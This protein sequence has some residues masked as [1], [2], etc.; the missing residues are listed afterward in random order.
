MSTVS[1][2][3]IKP[4][5]DELGSKN[6]EILPI[7]EVG[8]LAVGGTQLA[9]GYLNNAEKTA[10]AFIDSPYGI[11]YRTGDKAR[12][13]QDGTL[14][15]MGRI[16][17]GQVKLRGQ[18]IEL[19]E[20]EHA[21]LKTRGCHGVSVRVIGAILVAFCAVESFITEDDITGTCT[22]WL[23]Q[24]MVPGEVI[25]MEELPRLPSGKVDTK[26]LQTEF[27]Q[28]KDQFKAGEDIIENVDENLLQVLQGFFGSD[29]SSKTDLVRRG[30]DSLTAIGL[31]SN[32][33]RAG[34]DIKATSLLKVKT[35]GNILSTAI[36]IE[37]AD[38]DAVDDTSISYTGKLQEIQTH[39]LESELAHRQ[40]QDVIPCTSLQIA[41]LSETLRIGSAY[42][43]TVQ[44][45]VCTTTTPS[46]ILVAIH[47]LI[48]HNEDLRS[49]FL[50]HDS[51]FYCIIFDGIHPN[52][53][54]IS[55]EP[56]PPTTTSSSLLQ[57]FKIHIQQT[58]K[59]GVYHIQLHLHHSIYD[60]WTLDLLKSDLAK[61]I[62]KERLPER[63]QF[64]DVVS[65]LQSRT[66]EQY[67]ERAKV[68]W[69]DYL[70]GWSKSPF[71]RLTPKVAKSS[72]IQTTQLL[73]KLPKGGNQTYTGSKQ[74]PFQAALSLVWA[75][76]VGLQDVV[77]G[78]VT[79]GRTIPVNNIENIMGPCI[80]S[81]PLRINMESMTTID[82]LVNSISSSNRRMM[83]HTTLSQ[84]GIK[85]L[86]NLYGGD[87]LYDVL[88]VYQE[89][90]EHQNLAGC[91]V[92]ELS[93]IDRLETRLVLEVYPGQDEV[94]LQATFHDADF[95]PD[96]VEIILRQISQISFKICENPHALLSSVTCFEQ[97]I[98][99]YNLNLENMKCPPS[100]DDL[101][102]IVEH[103]VA[104]YPDRLAVSFATEI[105]PAIFNPNAISFFELNRNA[106]RIAH[107]LLSQGVK[108]GDIIPIVMNKSIR[109]YTTILGILKAG[110]GYLPLLPTTP[111]ARIA[112]IFNQAGSSLCLADEGS[113]RA[114]PPMS[115]VRLIL[116]D[117]ESME[118]FSGTNPSVRVDPSS[119]A[120]V[121]YTSGT[122]GTPKGVTVSQKNI[123]SNVTYLG[124]TYPEAKDKPLNFL[125]ACSQAFDVS[126][127][128]IFYAWHRGM[129]LCA[130]PNDVLFADLEEA[131]RKFEIT[132]LSL[133]PTI[134]SL[135][136][137]V[138]VPT[139]DFLVTAGEPMTNAVHA[140]WNQLLWQ[141]YGPSETT[142]ICSVKKMSAD[143]YIEHLGLVFDNTSVVV[144]QPMSFSTL[145]IGWAGELCFGGDQ[146]ANGYLNMPRLTAEKFFEHPTYGRIYR[147]GDLG[148][149]LPD[150]SL[151]I[152]GRIDDQI[153]LRGQRIE[154]AEV[155][156]IVSQVTAATAA[157]TLVLKQ[158][159]SIGEWLVTFYAGSDS[160]KDLHVLDP[161]AELQGAVFAELHSRL[162]PYMVPSYL[163]PVS[164][165]P[166]TS[167]G[168]VDKRAINAMFSQLSKEYLQ[169]VVHSTTRDDDRDWNEAERSVALV[170]A[171]SLGVPRAE[172]GRWTPLAI[173]GLDSI[174]A[175]QVSRSLSTAFTITVPIS[176]VLKRP[177][178]AQL[179]KML[180]HRQANQKTVSSRQYFDQQ[181]LKSITDILAKE[182]K[183]VCEVLPCSPLQEAMASRGK[184]SYYNKSLLRLRV[185]PYEMRGYWQHMCDRHSI[186]RTCF[187]ST[188]STKYP[189][190]QFVL[191]SWE[192]PWHEFTVT[193]PSL[194]NAIGE[195]LALVPE[196]LD[197]NTPPLSLALIRYRESSF[198]SFICHH[199]LYDGVAMECLWREVEAL[200]RG[201]QL[202]PAI[203]YGPFIHPIMNLPEDNEK[204]WKQQLVNFQPALLFPHFDQKSIEQVTHT[205]TIDRSLHTA[206]H[207]IK[208]LGISL[209][210]VCQAAITRV[211]AQVSQQNDVCFGNVMNGRTISVDGIERLVAPCF[212]TVP[213]RQNL[214]TPV[215]NID[216]A[217]DLLE[218]NTELLEHQ[219]TPLRQVQ[220]I[221]ATDT[222][223]LF[224]A[225]LLVQQPLQEMDDKIWTLEEDAGTM[226]LPLVCEV[227]PCPSLD[228][229]IL[230]L[231]YDM[232]SVP[233]ELATGIAELFKYIFRQILE[234]PHAI[235]GQE[236]IPDSLRD[237]IRHHRLHFVSD[238][239]DE[240]ETENSDFSW[241][242]E[243]L[244]VRNVLSE[245]SE[246]STGNIERTTSLFKLGLDSIN[247]VQVASLLRQRHYLVSASDI[248]ECQSCLKIARRIF[249]NGYKPKKDPGQY[250]FA[251]FD[252]EARP[253][254]QETPLVLEVLPCT[255]MQ[256]AML[257]SFLSSEG[258]NYLNVVSLE[259]QEGIS[260][261]NVADKWAD[262][263]KAHSMLRTGFAPIRHTDCTYAMLQYENTSQRQ[264]MH[265]SQSF[266]HTS[267]M[268]DVSKDIQTDLRQPPWRLAIVTRSDRVTVH[269]A[270]HHAIY[271]ATSLQQMLTYFGKLL[272]GHTVQ[273]VE[274]AHIGLSQIVQRSK[275]EMEAASSFWKQMGE[276]VT[277]NKFPVLTPLREVDRHI[278]TEGISSVLAV[279]DIH[280]MT[281]ALG[282]SVQTAIL[283]SWTRVL[284][285]YTGEEAVVFGVTLSGRTCEST[286]NTPIPCLTTV[287]VVAQN[288]ASNRNLLDQLMKWV[289]NMHQHQFLPLSRIQKELGY[290]AAAVFDTLVAYQKIEQD[291]HERPWIQ[292]EDDATVE[293]P[294]SLEVEPSLDG[295]IHIRLTYFSDVLPSEQA[296]LLL[297]Q[298]DATIENLLRYPDGQQS[299]LHSL[300]SEIFAI[301]PPLE[302]IMHAPVELLHQFVEMRARLNPDR[303]A[304]EHVSGFHENEP[305]R[306][307]WTFAELDSMGNRVAN[308]L[309]SRTTAGS[310]IAVHFDKYPEA[311]FAILGIL[312][313]GSAFVAL[314]FNAPNAR[315]EFILQ[316]SSA[317]ILL[318]GGEDVIDF[319][320]PCPVIVVDEALLNEYSESPCAVN[321]EVSPSSTCYCLYTSGT[322]GTPKGCEITHENTVQCMMAFQDLFKGH[323]ADNSR[324]LQFAALHFDV[325]VLE[326]YW[327]WSVGMAVVAA[328]KDLILD[329]LIGFIN[330]VNITHI[331]LT[332]SLARL[333]HPDT[334][335]S[336]CQ[337]VFITGGEQLKQ[338]ILDAWGSKAVIYNAYGP[339]EATIGVTTYQRVPQNGR[340]SNI[341]RQFRNVGSYVFQKDTEIPVFRGAVGELCVSGKLVGKGYLNRP[342]LTMEKFPILKIFGERIYR[343]GDLV[344]ILHDGCFEFLG[345]AD[346]QVK[347][348]G[349]RLE[350]GEIDHVIRS[351]STIHDVATLVAKHTLSGKDVLVSFIVREKMNGAPLCVLKDSNGISSEAKDVCRDK[352][353]G[354]MVPSYFLLLPY[355][356]LSP[357]NKAEAKQLRKI[358]AELS[359]EDLVSF[360]SSAMKRMVDT[361]GANYQ[362]LINLISKFCNLDQDILTPSASIF[363][364]GVDSITVLQLSL[365]LVDGG[366][367]TAS[368][369]LILRNPVVADLAFALSNT[370]LRDA[371]TE[372]RQVKLAVQACEH[373]FRSLVFR[374]LSLSPLEVEYIYPCSPLQQGMLAKTA[375]EDGQGSYFNTFRLLLKPNASL[376]RFKY[377]LKSLIA[378]EP[379]LRTTFIHSPA[380]YIQVARRALELPYKEYCLA[381]NENLDKLLD[382]MRQEWIVANTPQLRV[383]LEVVGVA[384]ENNSTWII[385]HIFHG[386]YDGTSF[387]LM[388]KKLV[389]LYNGSET[390]PGSSFSVALLHG[391]LRN[392]DDAKEEWKKHL[393]GWSPANLS[394]AAADNSSVPISAAKVLEISKIENLRSRN[395]V[396]LQ[397]VLL[398]AWSAVLQNYSANAV[399]TGVIVSG[400]LINIPGVDLAI[401]PLFNTLPFFAN[402]SPG[403][404]WEILLKRCQRF[405]AMVLEDPHVP[406]QQLQK[407]TSSG[408]S[409]FENLF[410]YQI[411]DKEMAA[412]DMPWHIQDGGLNPDYP[413]ALE[414]TKRCDG[415]MQLLLVAQSDVTNEAKLNRLLVEFED[416]LESMG[417]N[418]AVPI[419]VPSDLPHVSKEEE[420]AKTVTET[421]PFDWTP[422]A[423]IMRQELQALSNVPDADITASTT[424]LELGLDSIDAV[425]LS[426]RLKRQ[427]LAI[428]PSTIMKEGSFK[429]I[430]K[431]LNSL[432]T[433]TEG[434]EASVAQDI[435]KNL[436]NHV[437]AAG[438]DISTIEGVFPTTHL[439]DSMVAGMIESDFA[440]YFNHEIL[441]VA[442]GID[443]S[444]LQ[445]AWMKLFEASP[446]LRTGFVE[447]SDPKS[448]MIYAQVVYK[449]LPAI[450]TVVLGSMDDLKGVIEK[451]TSHAISNAARTGLVSLVLAR[452]EDRMFY[453]LSIS[454]ALY[455]GWSLGLLHED[456]KAAYEG[457]ITPRPSSENFLFRSSNSLTSEATDFWTNYLDGVV[458]TTICEA[459]FSTT[460]P[461]ARAE[462]MSAVKMEKINAFCRTQ[463]ISLQSLCQSCWAIILARRTRSLDV[464]FGAVLSGRDFEDAENL[465]FPT[466][467]TVAVRC[468]LHGSIHSFLQYMEDNISELRSYQMFPL[469]K[470]KA[471]ANLDGRV[472][473]DSLFL[474]Q[475]SHSTEASTSQTL[476]KSVQGSASVDYPVCV[477]AAVAEGFLEWTVACQ[478]QSEL[479]DE[480]IDELDSTIRYVLHNADE[481]I[482]AFTRAGVQIAGCRPME[483]AQNKNTDTQS[484]K[485][486]LPI[487]WNS[488]SSTIRQVL[489]QV[490]NV[491]EESIKAS[492]NLY[493]LGLDSI[494][495]IK[496]STLLK[497]QGLHLRP[498]D[499]VRAPSIMHMAELAKSMKD[500]IETP[501]EGQRSWESWTVPENVGIDEILQQVG[502]SQGHVEY[503]LPALPMQVYMI[504]TW[505]NT[506][507]K[508]FYPEFTYTLSGS[509]S[510]VDVYRAWTQVVE[511]LPMLRTSL[512]A[513]GQEELPFIQAITKPGVAFSGQQPFV[514]FTVEQGLDDPSVLLLR[515]RIHHA[516]YD[517][518]SLPATMDAL[519]T[520]LR[521][522]VPEAPISMHQ[523]AH[524]AV[525]THTMATRNSRKAFWTNYL[526]GYNSTPR[527]DAFT[528]PRTS[529]FK[530]GA[531]ANA[532]EL[533]AAAARYGIST[534]A[535]IFAAYALCIAR[536]ET[537]DKK[538]HDYSDRSSNSSVV[539]G[540]YLANRTDER[541]PETLP[542]LN[543]VPLRVFLPSGGDDADI[544]HMALQIHK[545]VQTL[546]TTNGEEG[547]ANVGLWEIAQWTGVKVNK[548]VNFLTLPTVSEGQHQQQPDMR[549]TATP[550]AA[551]EQSQAVATPP[552][553]VATE[554]GLDCVLI[555]NNVVR[556]A[557]PVSYLY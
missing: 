264:V 532:T 41:M 466:M 368:P 492:N 52:C 404:S 294:V 223:S 554:R 212:N 399:T 34:Y 405:N 45:E 209:L 306:K 215:A 228:S 518:V 503:I 438:I 452:L 240:L 476:F 344:R 185:D 297:Q 99:I 86:A 222:R 268:L 411:E 468:I 280:Q 19:G 175:I 194:D 507:G 224:D 501:Y 556:N 524:N 541:S 537:A 557:Y 78:S 10:A 292:K 38:S 431:A 457:E 482:V 533:S 455:D 247:A 350:L 77:V 484:E 521:G 460:P 148:R 116:I 519:L 22:E 329:D 217:K 480:L 74:I 193:Q 50:Q 395:N 396:T 5:V 378:T 358:F 101:A 132:H 342:D 443:G 181:F 539:F 288:T 258:I 88:F 28:S 517:G 284:A 310:I 64:R 119:P 451:S 551:A 293:F 508:I 191:A 79:S 548:F 26:I 543:L 347:L 489:S 355:I 474:L 502:I 317:P 169:T 71:P 356:P 326:Q 553:D 125:Q 134:A 477:E 24:F 30:L 552:E 208:S 172:I 91:F 85:K 534:Q 391:P 100:L 127:F 279:S 384:D 230:D 105:S 446:I 57:P 314:D 285:C 237:G 547:N 374:E 390:Q 432:P 53:V 510:A 275:G 220:K 6:F 202:R 538:D 39:E 286:I 266:D 512:V 138:N 403:Q 278:L 271:D 409:L 528:G 383:P 176:A 522:S 114:I 377:A 320:V 170:M 389:S 525:S 139:V 298:F 221:A 422:N 55:N 262:L 494:T 104:L 427:H 304:L 249:E 274:D 307:R 70:F 131:I 216:L 218:L 43:N 415:S 33:R 231:H 232:T 283:A 195:H 276:E 160:A 441:E 242:E 143:D 464:V 63:A 118:D 234:S 277:V 301:S 357:N 225:L 233:I 540:I 4:A 364:F 515:L 156:G 349:Q 325:S 345:R 332:P 511:Q 328:K 445:T 197:S 153:K 46:D 420:E 410:A 523:W 343:T 394:L 485:D 373:K 25:L 478:S 163:I 322:T 142:N 419:Q 362:T 83:D 111:Q 204:F 235:M 29:L 210:S 273:P 444:T 120:Y 475:K 66:R 42:W 122:T 529:L 470:A 130:A 190:A 365:F 241:T 291:I 287:P 65:F 313:S 423:N 95:P 506:N 103:A 250:D 417:K 500:G 496:V 128:E 226:D 245:L 269:L 11:V 305:I 253:L 351:V 340:P 152:L 376:I 37:T 267:W 108:A 504:S 76:I 303:L 398:A 335:P 129:C 544:V 107:F 400:R 238:E 430:V 263:T 16:A 397:T 113:L 257:S 72:Q 177:T 339:T 336:L 136:D 486:V 251:A 94:I 40:V 296:R 406:L 341:G 353:P 192:L 456:L 453:V 382:S 429:N 186:L 439:Q 219:F 463:K 550:A 54:T 171:D 183:T 96:L 495:A 555:A 379:I 146:V 370:S 535:I 308:M 462:K 260:A 424:W 206:Q 81:L 87:Q 167:S 161:V 187:V 338:E 491:P 290:P 386:L 472:F 8:E 110:C 180:G 354:Y 162:L 408:K 302:P 312:K 498:T 387:E 17:D 27:E 321:G 32:L 248:V 483:F 93:H 549:L 546:S 513:T 316:D 199:A 13:H 47:R 299:D 35:I 421:S 144:L 520:S 531:F 469:R 246:V 289:S 359:Q 213:I 244:A 173:L 256:C 481:E 151:V 145:P 158:K 60:G 135:I 435:K 371:A 68:F 516:L 178:V 254:L 1:C 109:L 123:A 428:S 449:N 106:N 380:G 413:L 259:M 255:P 126:V 168:K 97:D 44:L 324:W 542:T 75:G 414:V 203:S 7:G 149:M 337:G 545:D 505:Q 252:M 418:G 121:I 2:F 147:S 3:I 434:R 454:H 352:L 333:T 69:A 73:C 385:F 442:P 200:A 18:R 141:G 458:S 184:K 98:S 407:W 433:S 155:N 372:L 243:E 401:G 461:A 426:A 21:I 272:T 509:V 198:L 465:M 36:K 490:S 487:G 514:N 323:W 9:T 67:D 236:T 227:T 90:P 447:V 124:A 196:P 15:C 164:H 207:R 499:L 12:L 331:D 319:D 211:L 375:V 115:T 23:P 366:F 31:S 318:T 140:R 189:I 80:A 388:M 315:K 14:E 479:A 295:T 392:H 89:S 527:E 92:Q 536:H 58:A 348:R 327:S 459:S 48:S 309:S 497:Q 166:L 62:S 174:S 493:H 425:Q 402:L 346:D 363:D 467:N 150:G 179:A 137:P 49:G 526:N 154:A 157:V 300:K 51:T 159:D 361:E 61:A 117:E 214:S 393:Q 182:S 112:E 20:I 133:T 416:M 261:M 471:V 265:I 330:N 188:S 437:E 369:A 381:R 56:A 412:R 311:Y 84:L 205:I 530:P 488:T 448:E 229:L 201:E 360:G 82:D 450:E 440:W 270:I 436:R 473:F 367:A 334:V 281:K 282:I 165:I 239:I 102:S 59:P